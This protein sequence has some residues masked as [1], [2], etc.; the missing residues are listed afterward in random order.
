MPV[1]WETCWPDS[2]KK[3][4]PLTSRTRIVCQAFPVVLL[5]VVYQFGLFSLAES[6]WATA[7]R[8]DFWTFSPPFRV[9]QAGKSKVVVWDVENGRHSQLVFYIDTRPISGGRSEPVCARQQVGATTWDIYPSTT[10]H[11]R[12]SLPLII[13]TKD[14]IRIARQPALSYPKDIISY[15]YFM[16]TSKTAN[17]IKY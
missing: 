7:A 4:R 8:Q 15:F 13:K 2:P 5:V 17:R 11:L 16:H 14:T 12:E 9:P 1:S 3:A 6:L 10:L